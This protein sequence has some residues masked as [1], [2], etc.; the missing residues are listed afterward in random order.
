[1]QFRYL[2]V[3]VVFL[4]IAVIMHCAD[5]RAQ[6]VVQKT[7]RIQLL[8]PDKK[9]A[10]SYFGLSLFF[11]KDTTKSI[12]LL[13]DA[14]GE[15][16]ATI[17]Q[18]TGSV[19]LKSAS[20]V[21]RIDTTFTLNANN[22]KESIICVANYIVNQLSEVKV[23]AGRSTIYTAEKIS[24]KASDFKVPD[25]PIGK[26]L[27]AMIPSISKIEN[28]YKIDGSFDP[29]FYI[30]GSRIVYTAVENLPLETID[31]V[32]IIKNSS[33]TSGLKPNQVALNIVTKKKPETILGG[34]L[35]ANNS[36]TQRNFGAFSTLYLTGKRFFVNLMLNSYSAGYDISSASYWAKLPGGE[37]VYSRIMQG[38]TGTVPKIGTLSANY[39]MSNKVQINYSLSYNNIRASQH[40]GSAI[41]QAN[42]VSSEEYLNSL[43][44]PLTTTNFA[45][46]N[47]KLSKESNLFFRATHN[48]S[49]TLIDLN[50]ENQINGVLS[51]KSENRVQD[52][53]FLIGHDF[54]VAKAS[55]EIGGLFQHNDNRNT[56]E[57]SNLQSAAVNG[58][59]TYNQSFYTVYSRFKYPF[60][61]FTL[62]LTNRLDLNASVLNG[63]RMGNKLQY[64]PGLNIYV[65]TKN[66]GTFSL[67]ASRQTILPGSDDLNENQRRQTS[68]ITSSGSQNV[69]QQ[70]NWNVSLTHNLSGDDFELTNALNYEQTEGLIAFGPYLFGADGS[71]QRNKI[72]V[73][74][75]SILSFRPSLNL[76]VSKRLSFTCTAVAGYYA[77][78]TTE[79][80]YYI[81]NSGFFVAPTITV[82]QTNPKFVN[83]NLSMSYRNKNF[84]PFEIKR[85]Q[86]PALSLTLS[87]TFLKKS[88]TVTGSIYDAFNTSNNSKSSGISPVMYN[89]V[90]LVQPMRSIGLSMSYLFHAKAFRYS[91]GSK[92]I[93]GRETKATSSN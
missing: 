37:P 38:R 66:S 5:V 3:I 91:G 83:F 47:I 21:L 54:K 92:G 12:A 45:N 10:L 93:K 63:N 76:D 1:M 64:L 85:Q 43:F 87:R 28:N 88:L 69:G 14:K 70:I 48:F 58:E 73:A 55:F 84:F 41:K 34:M 36:F 86:A 62:T 16:L 52:F 9:T 60:R 72:N 24:Y 67:I 33:L 20:S 19:T 59:L 75:E 26:N 17:P 53:N 11:G 8:Q 46:L 79:Q 81:E 42:G 35:S 13:S 49:S 2:S 80:G 29:V 82:V 30:N 22:P 56:F 23:S 77:S 89:T 27:L 40:V 90:S 74:N 15:T 6:A 39:D 18:A 44:R 7:L 65:P 50:L 4:N 31:R 57:L 51:N 25:L 32:E 61:Y 71:I 78:N 68:G